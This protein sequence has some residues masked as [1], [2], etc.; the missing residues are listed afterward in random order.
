MHHSNLIILL[1]NSSEPYHKTILKFNAFCKSQSI[2]I[3]K[4][5]ITSPNNIFTEVLIEVLTKIC[6]DNKLVFEYRLIPKIPDKHLLDA[7]NTVIT[8]DNTPF[9][10]T[11]CSNILEFNETITDNAI[12]DSTITDSAITDWTITDKPQYISYTV[13]NHIFYKLFYITGE[14]GFGGLHLN[15]Y[16]IVGVDELITCAKLVNHSHHGYNYIK[17]LSSYFHIC[18]RL[19]AYMILNKYE[20]II[21][22]TLP[23]DEMIE[24]SDNK[25]W[26]LYYI[27]ALSYFK[28]DNYRLSIVCCEKC[29]NIHQLRPEPY[30]L[31]SKIYYNNFNYKIA[32]S[33]IDKYNTYDTLSHK[34]QFTNTSMGHFSLTY[35]SILINDKLHNF[36]SSIDIVN[37]V[38]DTELTSDN[39]TL[40]LNYLSSQLKPT[41]D[42]EQEIPYKYSM[43]SY[44][45]TLNYKFISSDVTIN[46]YKNADNSE[47][48]IHDGSND[49]TVPI[50][51]ITV[52]GIYYNNQ[53]IL[54]VTSIHPIIINKLD[55][56]KMVPF[57][58]HDSPQYWNNYVFLTKFISYKNLYICLVESK[59]ND[60]E[61]FSLIRLCYLNKDTLYPMGL[62]AFIKINIALIQDIFIDDDTLIIIGRDNN[63]SIP[64]TSLYLEY[65]I[66][67]N[68]SPDIYIDINNDFEV[69]IKCIGYKVPTVKYK[70]I[71]IGNTDPLISVIYDSSTNIFSNVDT[72]FTQLI[73][74]FIYLPSNIVVKN[75][76]HD[77]VFYSNDTDTY[78]QEYLQ[79]CDISVGTD[80]TVCKYI[81]ISHTELENLSSAQLSDIITNKTLVITL[82]DEEDISDDKL[83]KYKDDPVIHKLFLLNIVKNVDYMEYVYQNILNDDQYDKREPYFNI[84][85]ENIYTTTNIFETVV[86]FH[87]SECDHMKRIDIS[88]SKSDYKIDLL[89]R[90]YSKT[91]NTTLIEILKFI[92]YHSHDITVFYETELPSLI[93]KLNILGNIYKLSEID[94]NEHVCTKCIIIVDT[95]HNIANWSSVYDKESLI[96]IL[97]QNKVIYLH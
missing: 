96:F 90:L 8:R 26:L 78:L 56:G 60:N 67:I 81:I 91:E 12:T 23:D 9:F 29:I 13:A 41:D 82:L 34:L 57:M 75:K 32:K 3:D 49:F 87:K 89:T 21:S 69:D 22:Y 76:T 24:L 42:T 2:I 30:Y 80:Y 46:M 47:L 51:S 28:L 52:S 48:I 62:S 63:Q 93:V 55:S 1:Y 65:N 85:I 73:T 31:I 5:Y 54:I 39:R 17:E 15:N 88:S 79:E 84:D 68:Y 18:D 4:V 19:M 36:D 71:I 10:F 66:P 27:R 11:E 58:T 77:V 16:S 14:T 7:L 37:N 35:L 43:L 20:T 45:L 70:N 95:S 94:I 97:D 25:Q 6:L 83:T 50:D 86:D 38:I 33:I 72:G 44:R 92:L 53:N 59:T 40:L 64:L 74:K 61:Q